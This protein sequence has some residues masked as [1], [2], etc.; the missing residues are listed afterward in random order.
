MT[1]TNEQ[2]NQIRPKIEI[3]VKTGDKKRH[4]NKEICKISRKFH[5]FTRENSLK[6][7]VEM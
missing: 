5:H 3:E 4:F 7:Q 1:P 6:W 2:F